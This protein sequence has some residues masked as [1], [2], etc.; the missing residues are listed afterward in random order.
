MHLPSDASIKYKELLEYLQCHGHAKVSELTRVL[1]LSESTVRRAL[2][3]LEAEGKVHRFHGGAAS[4]DPGKQ[5]FVKEREVSRSEEKDA[6]GRLAASFVEEGMTLLL[7]GG[8]TVHAM[9]PYLKGK[10]L[11]VITSSLPVVNDLAWEEHMTLILL[12]GVLNPPEM[13][14]RGGLMQLALGRLRADLM[15]TGVTGLHPIHG[16]MTDD[17]NG[18]ETYT[19]CMNVSDQ[20]YV[21]ADHTKCEHYGGTTVLCELK[22]ISC[23]ITDDHMPEATCAYYQEQAPRLLLAPV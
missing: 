22:D 13:E 12:G 16:L 23:L 11:T 19:T 7:M 17:P 20:V 1:F 3:A 9:C 4:T 18:V 21:L 14:V 10:R 8:T 5:A 15:F 2:S 6:I